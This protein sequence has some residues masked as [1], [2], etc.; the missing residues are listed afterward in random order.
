MTP[1]NWFSDLFDDFPSSPAVNP[2]SG[3]PMIEDTW[4][5]VAGN[6]FGADCANDCGH[7][8]FDTT[9]T[10]DSGGCGSSFDS[11]CGCDSFSSNS[12]D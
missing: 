8:L 11:F 7:D 6:P 10:F 5:D 2:G 4:I 1:F 9:S 3:L 12:W